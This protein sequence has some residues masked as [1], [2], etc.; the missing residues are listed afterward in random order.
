MTSRDPYA[1]ARALMQLLRDDGF[2][3]FA[4]GIRLAIEG[5]ATGTE[6]FKALRWNFEKIFAT[7]RC[8]NATEEIAMHLY[9]QLGKH[10]SKAAKRYPSRKNRIRRRQL[11]GVRA[12]S[13]SFS[14]K[15]LIVDGNHFQLRWRV[16]SAV[17]EG[18]KVLVLFDPDS[19]LLDQE[20][21]DM[22][23]RGAPAIRNLIA[24]SKTGDQLWEAEMPE[25]ADYYYHIVSHNPLIVHSFSS[26][27]CEI[28]LASGAIIRN[29]FLK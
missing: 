18:D 11:L 25:A 13:I 23:R 14:N 12:L 9:V 27:K 2:N 28:D 17:E 29:E 26:Y 6:I 8:S 5:G 16:L 22:R 15:T 7:N 19:Y 4:N 24:V 10:L 21:K 3:E 1:E 20:Y